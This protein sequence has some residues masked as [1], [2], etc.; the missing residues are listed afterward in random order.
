MGLFFLISEWLESRLQKTFCKLYQCQTQWVRKNL[1]G[2]ISES[3]GRGKT[4]DFK[5]PEGDVFRILLLIS[6]EN[7]S[8]NILTTWKSDIDPS[9]ACN[10]A[11]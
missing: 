3:E 5:P 4:G 2:N 10:D 7:L 1:A 9:S 8:V 11:I 6:Y